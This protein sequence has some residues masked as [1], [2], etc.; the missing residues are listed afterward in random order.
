MQAMGGARV[1]HEEN[2]EVVRMRGDSTLRER[3]RRR[4]SDRRTDQGRRMIRDRRRETV[5]GP[6]E[7]RSRGEGRDRKS[8]VEGKR[9]DL[10][11]RRIIKKKKNKYAVFGENL[12]LR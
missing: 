6:V 4:G 12:S 11:G 1:P 7:R 5:E 2:E 8:V 3:P 10:G 9:V